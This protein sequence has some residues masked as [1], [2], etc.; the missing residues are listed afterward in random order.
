MEL[1]D[2][3]VLYKQAAAPLHAR[4]DVGCPGA[5]PGKENK[6]DRILLTGD[7][8]SPINPPR[9]CVF[10]TRCPKYRLLVGE[11]LQNLYRSEV[12][13]LEIKVPGHFAAC[14]FPEAGADIAAAGAAGLVAGAGR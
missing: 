8:P 12:P 5:R 10:H 1:A 4:A 13:P 3:D 14:H 2:R 7:L 9:G 11:Q 6:R